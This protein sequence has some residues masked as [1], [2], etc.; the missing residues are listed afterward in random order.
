MNL[1][2]SELLTWSEDQANPF[3]MLD[4]GV[5]GVCREPCGG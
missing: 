2:E 5:L 1:N 4:Q 3:E